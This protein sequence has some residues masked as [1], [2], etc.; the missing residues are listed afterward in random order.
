MWPEVGRSRHD[1]R[2]PCHPHPCSRRSK[3][4]GRATVDH[5]VAHTP[6]PEGA[7]G[8]AG[9]CHKDT[10]KQSF[11]FRIPW[12]PMASW[13]AGGAGP[14]FALGQED[15]PPKPRANNH[16]PAYVCP[17]SGGQASRDPGQTIISQTYVCPGS[18]GQASRSQGKQS[19]VLLPERCLIANGTPASGPQ[20]II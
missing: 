9:G 5:P 13:A 19:S 2:S 1:H 15:K 8:M 6:A 11:R 3:G 17:G 10:L 14:M 18:G 7:G 16:Q 20:L 12:E 4:D